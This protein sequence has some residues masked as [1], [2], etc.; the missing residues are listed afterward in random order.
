MS[1]PRIPSIPECTAVQLTMVCVLI[2]SLVLSPVHLYAAPRSEETN[3]NEVRESLARGGWDVIYGDLIN[4][5]DYAEFGL[6]VAASIATENPA[7]IYAFFDA[8]LNAQFTKIRNTAPDILQSS[9]NSLVLQAFRSQGTILRQGRLEISGGLATY[10]RWERVVY[11]EPRTYR[12]KQ[13]LPIGWTWSV[14]TTTEKVERTVPLPN[15]FQPYIRYRWQTSSTSTPAQSSPSSTP[16][17]VVCLVNNTNRE[18]NY[19]YRWGEDEWKSISVSANSNRYHSWTYAS[20][21]QS[22]P[23]FRVRFDADFTSSTDYKVYLLKRY[24]NSQKSCDGAKKYNF[25]DAGNSTIELYAV[26]D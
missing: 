13:S 10:K 22:S 15:N 11:H 3:R 9:L 19:S 17:A 12:C 16:Y 7:P 21:A 4:E 24:R 2:L 8:Q 6:A 20:G 18:I 23:D 14:C 1:V 5:G 25:R 26:G